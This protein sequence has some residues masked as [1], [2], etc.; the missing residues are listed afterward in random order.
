MKRIQLTAFNIAILIILFCNT[1]IA[2]NVT[3]NSY[4]KNTLHG[5]L[6]TVAIVN[7][8]TVFYERILTES[9]SPSKF[10]TFA[11]VGFQGSNAID[12]WGGDNINGNSLIL[13]GGILTGPNR[14]HFEGALGVAYMM[15]ESSS[16]IPAFTLGYRNQVPGK[17]FMFR[18]GVGLPELLYV[19]VGYSF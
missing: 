2:Q 17:K 12:V 19:G 14:S 18:I 4:K 10:T 7:T 11:R 15:T 13:Q 8:A 9:T 16:F 6:G 3:D 5:S 1:L